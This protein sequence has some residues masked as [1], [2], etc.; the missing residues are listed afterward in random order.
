MT[1]PPQTPTGP[2]WYD[3][4]QDPTLLRYFD[5]VVW[6]THT[7]PRRSPTAQASTIGRAT[8]GVIPGTA[9]HGQYGEHGPGQ[10]QGGGVP[11]AGYNAYQ[12]GWTTTRSDQLPDG[13]VLAQWWRRLIGRILDI[14]VT[15]VLTVIAAAPWLGQATS[16]L[17][18]F[19]DQT[20]RAAQDGTAPPDQAAFMSD[21]LQAAV[22]ITLVGIVVSLVYEL[23]FLTTRGATPGKMVMGTF[24]RRVEGPGRLSVL[25]VLRRQAIAITTALL[26]LVPLVG[27]LASVL[28]FLDPA[29]LLWDAKRQC[30]HDK[31][32]DTVVLLR[33]PDA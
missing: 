33:N 29:W 25:T 12:E 19:L 32:A 30:L 27:I 10:W 5:G 6:T 13:A 20:A 9:G 15:L 8:P 16:S 2:G 17:S 7:T 21:F 3:D 14:V 22:P 24:V 23:V 11:P 18:D 26:N 28:R 1:Q 4:L 31:L